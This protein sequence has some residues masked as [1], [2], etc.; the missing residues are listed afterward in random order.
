MPNGF[1]DFVFVVH[2]HQ[3]VGNFDHIFAQVHDDC[4]LNE[5]DHDNQTRTARTARCFA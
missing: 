4:P 5:G 3:P 1:V 2:N